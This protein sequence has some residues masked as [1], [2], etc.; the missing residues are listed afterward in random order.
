MYD[1]HAPRFTKRFA[2]VRRAMVEGVQAYAE[3]VRTRRFPG[4]EH[5]YSIDPAELERFKEIVSPGRP[6]DAAD[7]M[8]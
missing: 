4:T 5:T 6:W 7:F 8:G 1:G 3:E 2:E